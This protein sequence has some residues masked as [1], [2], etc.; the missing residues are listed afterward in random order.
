M[1]HLSRVLHSTIG[2]YFISFM[3]GMGLATLF[4]RVCNDK[5]CLQFNGP[6]VDEMTKKTYKFGEFCYKYDVQPTQCDSTKKTVNLDNT[7]AKL[8]KEKQ[9]E[10]KPF[11]WI[12]FT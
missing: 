7:E 11:S 6:V 10:K 5:S 4:R 8:I 1:L 2:H 12:P 9:D 3:L